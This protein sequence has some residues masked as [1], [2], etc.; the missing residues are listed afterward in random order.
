MSLLDFAGDGVALALQNI[1][2]PI[3][4]GTATLVG[5]TVT[6][7]GVKLTTSSRILLGV[8]TPNAGMNATTA[9][10]AAPLASRNVGA[11]TFVIQACIQAGTI[12]N[13]DVSTVDWAIIG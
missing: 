5:G 4:A 9:Y 6:V 1:A 10:I 8:V 7:S 11:G 3:Q 2:G 13:T 12:Q